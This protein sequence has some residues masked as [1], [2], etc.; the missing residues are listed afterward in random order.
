M[1]FKSERERVEL[2]VV[3]DSRQILEIN[4]RNQILNFKKII[5]FFNKKFDSMKLQKGETPCDDYK[6]PPI[7]E[8]GK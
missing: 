7:G 4:I 8:E 5:Y 3:T 6:R 1:K 2:Q